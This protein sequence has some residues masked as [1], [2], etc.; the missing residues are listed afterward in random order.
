MT[1]RRSIS[2]EQLRILLAAAEGRL[3]FD[4]DSFRYAIEGDD[5]PDRRERERLQKRGLI[6][7]PNERSEILTA[8]GK[9]A[10]AHAPISDDEP[11][12]YLFETLFA[13]QLSVDQS[14]QPEQGESK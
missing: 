9:D 3:S 5:P 4:M 6:S 10:L 8:K 14:D 12:P 7:R 2:S 11:K 1:V 13:T